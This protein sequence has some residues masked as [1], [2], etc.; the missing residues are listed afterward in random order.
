MGS[1]GNDIIYGGPGD[2]WLHGVSG[3]DAIDGGPCERHPTRLLGTICVTKESDHCERAGST[4]SAG[5]LRV[6][7][8]AAGLTIRR[9]GELAGVAHSRVIEYERGHHQ[10]SLKRAERLLAA[11]GYTLIALPGVGSLTTA[12]QCAD[13]IRDV[14][15]DGLDRGE[16]VAFRVVIQLHDDL[17]AAPNYLVGSLIAAPPPLTGD[18]RFDA[19]IA[20]LVEAH[21]VR[22]GLPVPPWVGEASRTVTPRWYPD[23]YESDDEVVPEVSQHGVA[24]RT[25]E[26]E[27][28]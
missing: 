7:R 6:A 14:L 21:V 5:L 23:G 22:C 1:G 19:L 2:D 9:Q 25:S 17:T 13:A 8:R 20:G 28:V 12:A 18:T 3:A 16:D 4:V 11:A 15:A 10:P 27:S 24:L 26:L